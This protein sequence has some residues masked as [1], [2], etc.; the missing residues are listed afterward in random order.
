M[1][2]FH[3]S[4]LVGKKYE[5]FLDILLFGKNKNDFKSPKLGK[6]IEHA[7]NFRCGNAK[8]K[9]VIFTVEYF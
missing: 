3:I 1:S 6:I 4:C 5:I 9:F 2:Q 7:Y 8:L